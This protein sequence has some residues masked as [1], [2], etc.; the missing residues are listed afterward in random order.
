[1]NYLRSLK[2]TF[3]NIKEIVCKNKTKKISSEQLDFNINRKNWT[4]ETSI[5][6]K[7]YGFCYDK[8]ILLSNFSSIPYGFN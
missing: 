5:K 2:I 4:I 8:R 7:N 6:T 3:E 1:M